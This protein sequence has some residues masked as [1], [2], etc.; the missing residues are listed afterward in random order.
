MPEPMTWA[1]HF[2]LVDKLK[3]EEQ[4]LQKQDKSKEAFVKKIINPAASWDD[5][6]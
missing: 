2:Q 5:L 3:K 4:E 1:S 6:R